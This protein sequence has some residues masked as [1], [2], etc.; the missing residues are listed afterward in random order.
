M[1]PT[2]RDDRT[3]SRVSDERPEGGD[4]SVVSATAVA[5]AEERGGRG[6]PARPPPVDALRTPGFNNQLY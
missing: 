1:E 5:L 4:S 3:T 2:S 6:P